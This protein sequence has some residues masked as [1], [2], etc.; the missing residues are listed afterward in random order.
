MLEIG[1]AGKVKAKVDNT[2]TA[3]TYGSGKIKVF[4]TPAMVALMENAAA[5]SV[6]PH[7]QVGEST[8]GI[9]I[10]V[11]HLK[12]TPVGMNVRSESTLLA[13]NGKRLDFEVTAFDD[14]GIIGRGKH[15]RYIIDVEKFM[16]KT[17]AKLEKN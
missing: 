16:T 3:D 9:S 5:E 10:S 11:E 14:A 8:V 15:S 12:A 1:I 7:L 2:N 13:I 17:L 4:A 6:L